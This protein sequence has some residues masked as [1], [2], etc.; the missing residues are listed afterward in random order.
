[1][2]NQVAVE[3]VSS[4]TACMDWNT[5]LAT[6]V[7]MLLATA[8]FSSD[9]AK[10]PSGHTHTRIRGDDT[11]SVLAVMATAWSPAG[12]PY[13]TLFSIVVFCM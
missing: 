12:S 2:L 5:G 3:G 8:T 7:M 10:G 11:I 6:A 1:M 9:M 13:T 4:R